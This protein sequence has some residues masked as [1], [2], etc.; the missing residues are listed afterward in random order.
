MQ[1]ERIIRPPEIKELA[2][3]GSEISS[4]RMSGLR[5]TLAHLEVI[6]I[7]SLGWEKVPDQVCVALI[8]ISSAD[9]ALK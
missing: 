8:H 5:E 3:M 7:A 1:S 4:W 6:Q 9:F 2:T